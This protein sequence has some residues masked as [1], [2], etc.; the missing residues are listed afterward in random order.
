VT[1]THPDEADGGHE[2]ADAH[3][4]RAEHDHSHD[5]R[6][7]QPHDE[8]SHGAVEEIHSIH[9]QSQGNHDA[10]G[11]GHGHGHDPHGDV[12]TQ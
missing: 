5:D 4:H 1:G 9:V 10:H 3:P 2:H 7:D 11:H 8:G 6:P 12:H